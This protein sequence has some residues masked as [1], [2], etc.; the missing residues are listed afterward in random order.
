MGTHR[1]ISD[2]HKPNSDATR[3]LQATLSHHAVLVYGTPGT[4]ETTFSVACLDM[5]GSC[6][7][8]GQAVALTA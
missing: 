1:G 3:A 6:L 2:K 7:R 5:W 4:G 8:P